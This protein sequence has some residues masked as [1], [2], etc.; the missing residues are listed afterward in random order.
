MCYSHNMCTIIGKQIY[1]RII[2]FLSVSQKWSLIMSIYIDGI[3]MIWKGAK[4]E[5]VFFINN[6]KKQ[7]KTIKF[8]SEI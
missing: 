2:L 5:F 1:G 6:L 4:E 7:H 3:F 8:D